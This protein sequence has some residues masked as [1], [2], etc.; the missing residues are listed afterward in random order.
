[1]ANSILRLI[2]D[3]IARGSGVKQTA[4]DVEKLGKITSK[5]NNVLG[6]FGLAMGAKEVLDFSMA[7]A[8]AARAQKDSENTLTSLVGSTQK[9]NEAIAQVKEATRGMISET[10]A[11]RAAFGLLD[12]GIAKTAE[13]AANYAL[14]GKALEASLGAETASYEKFLMLLDQGSPM[15]LNNFNLTDTMVEA[16]Q[17]L[18]ESNTNLEGSEA[19][20]Q[21]VRELALEKGLA[22]SKTMSEDTIAAEKFKAAS[23][24]L[25]AALGEMLVPAIAE[26]QTTWA[27]YF[28]TLTNGLAVINEA[29]ARF[30]EVGVTQ[31]ELSNIQT[32]MTAEMQHA[33]EATR[34]V[35]S[36]LD[37]M[38]IS[39]ERAATAAE[40][41]A[42]AMRNATSS[43]NALGFGAA[44]AA[45]AHDP[46]IR[47][48]MTAAQRAREEAAA[49][50]ELAA[51]HQANLA[52]MAQESQANQ[53]LLAAK[54]AAPELGAR[55]TEQRQ[56]VFEVNQAKEEEQ[57]AADKRQAA[58]AKK[59]AD[60]MGQAIKD[61]T[62]DLATDISSAVSDAVTGVDQN[63]IG[64][65]LGLD[66]ADANAGEA[67]RRMAA[68][69]A[70]GIQNEWAPALAAQLTGVQDKTAQA[71]VAAFSTGDDSKLK[72]AAQQL[73]LNP[74]VELFDAQL[75]A[76]QVEQKLRT[77]GLQQA[78]ND[79]VNALLGEKGLPA[80]QSVTQ[81]VGTAVTTT[82]DAVNTVGTNVAGV[83]TTAETAMGQ[84]SASLTG[85]LVS[86][87]TVT[88]RIGLLNKA[89][90]RTKVLA[91]EAG[92]AIGGLNP[93]APGASLVP[94]GAQ[95]RLGGPVN[96]I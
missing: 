11:A 65:L 77:D 38:N 45:E 41:E 23:E 2:I 87:D 86:I 63:V 79:K 33:I 46:L 43:L 18:I 56:A 85:T 93:P 24:D 53:N 10:G 8:A 91:G 70:G 28:Q 20:L 81:Q 69:A 92:A 9:Y 47:G 57:E 40:Q 94:N 83:A 72:A 67:V 22:L 27:G 58:L 19:R 54:E 74:I 60:T 75:I 52:Q 31:A 7:A 62:K 73:A 95:M 96:S 12:N 17:R 50:R 64:D 59:S 35:V 78:L 13:E 44:G 90:E 29:N 71:F 34:V 3:A 51:A 37:A 21:A 76:N 89:L 26:G 6:A 61:A 68:V 15:L 1:M 66:N 32:G 16:R 5:V 80:I 48:M 84:V 14:A 49:V 30:R 25:T 82:G 55:I 4:S 39:T 88:L 36:S 42:A